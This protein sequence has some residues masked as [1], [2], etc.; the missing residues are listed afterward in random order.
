MSLAVVGVGGQ[1]WQREGAKINNREG[2]RVGKNRGE[3]SE[4]FDFDYSIE[5]GAFCR[6]PLQNGTT[7]LFKKH[8]E[9]VPKLPFCPNVKTTSKSSPY[10]D[11]DIVLTFGWSGGA[12]FVDERS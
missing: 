5:P 4:I 3:S 6:D 1:L 12:F 10:E 8:L 2:S 7:R 11:Y 9:T